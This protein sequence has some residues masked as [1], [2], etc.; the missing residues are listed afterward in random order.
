MTAHHNAV[1]VIFNA[2]DD[3]LDVLTEHLARA[4]YTCVRAFIREFR[5]G[6]RDVSAFIREHDPRVVIW[7]IS[8][9]YVMNWSFLQATL[10]TPVVQ[11]RQVV[12]TTANVARLDEL[13]GAS[14]CAIE[15]SEW[16][17]DLERLLTSL[18]LDLARG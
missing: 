8:V 9:P 12:V 6:K 11:G 14:T 3:T 2:S 4:H 10:R 7:D 1:V 18:N 16:P 13:V 5:Q 17:Q 15:I